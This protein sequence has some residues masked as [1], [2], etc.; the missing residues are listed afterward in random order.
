MSAPALDWLRARVRGCFHRSGAGCKNALGPDLHV[1][2]VE[3][4]SAVVSEQVKS[5]TDRCLF[6]HVFQR[7][8]CVRRNCDYND[9][10]S[11]HVGGESAIWK[12]TH[13]EKARR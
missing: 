11:A 9:T 7:E 2:L 6:E 8:F 12:Q 1:L 13:A 4:G 3:T 5:L 10:A